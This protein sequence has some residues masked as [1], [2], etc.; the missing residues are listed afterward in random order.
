MLIDMLQHGFDQKLGVNAFNALLPVM[1]T[2]APP[3]A[4]PLCSAM[5][6]PPF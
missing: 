6:I 1:I 3:P 2:C 5:H 4:Q